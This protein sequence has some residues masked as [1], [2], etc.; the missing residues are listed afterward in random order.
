MILEIAAAAALA[1]AAG[2]AG[3]IE[4]VLSDQQAAWNSGDIAGFM[5]G[6]RESPDLRFASGGEV[7]TGWTETLARYRAR[8]DS[9]EKMGRLDFS[10]IDIDLLSDDAAIAFGRWTLR[11]EGDAPTGLFTLVFRRIDGRWVIVHDH[12]S[13]A[14]IP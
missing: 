11:R 9:P 2:P 10:D 12:T 1:A 7:T 3:D 6:Y 13:A 14:E 8:Y 4:A 5:A